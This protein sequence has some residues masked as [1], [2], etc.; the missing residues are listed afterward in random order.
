[1]KKQAQKTKKQAQKA[2]GINDGRIEHWLAQAPMLAPSARFKAGVMR[3]I[4]ARSERWPVKWCRVLFEPRALRWNFAGAT[5][6]AVLLGLGVG[7]GL[8]WTAPEAPS[9]SAGRAALVTVRFEAD[10]PRARD[11]AVIGDF[12]QWRSPVSLRR[13][14]DGVWRTEVALPPGSYE[15]VFVVDG[16]QWITDPRASYHRQDGFGNNNNVVVVPSV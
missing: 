9:T 10:L 16:N 1:M 13:D 15:Y 11:V 2:G 7:L 3:A 4:E 5:A 8:V 14:A 12:S 6:A